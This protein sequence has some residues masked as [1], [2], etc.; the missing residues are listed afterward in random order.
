MSDLFKRY[1]EAVA[2][3]TLQYGGTASNP[4]ALEFL[5]IRDLWCFPKYPSKTAIL[6]PT[7]NLTAELESFIDQNRKSLN[8]ADCWL[9]TW[10]NPQ[11]GDY[12]LDVSTGIKG[13]EAARETAIR[14]GNNE[15]RKIAAI[16]NPARNETI[17]L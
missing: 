17:F 3:K 12:Y 2:E 7:V 9:G 6:P 16:F 13:L 14:V 8:E 4:I 15:G 5:P 1:L 11:T 10:V